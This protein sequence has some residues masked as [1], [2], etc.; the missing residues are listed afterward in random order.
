[1]QLTD[2]YE[3]LVKNKPNSADYYESGL[4][5]VSKDMLK[6]GVINKPLEE[7]TVPELEIAIFNIFNNDFF[8]K[9]F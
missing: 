6:E 7:M 4:R 2:F 8:I 3:F 9:F 1:M 5:A